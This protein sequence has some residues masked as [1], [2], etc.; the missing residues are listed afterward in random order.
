MQ[1]KLMSL[2]VP[3]GACVAASVDVVM[4]S[5]T[6]SVAVVDA[7]VIVVNS[8]VDSVASSVTVVAS[9]VAGDWLDADVVGSGIL[10]SWLEC[11][12]L[13]LEFLRAMMV[14]ATMQLTS[15]TLRSRYAAR[16]RLFFHENREMING[17]LSVSNCST[18]DIRASVMARQVR[19]S[20][21]R[22]TAKRRCC[23]KDHHQSTT[24]ENHLPI[25]GSSCESVTIVGLTEC[26]SHSFS[27]ILMS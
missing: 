15:R 25:A 12:L 8:V 13:S 1:L 24:I 17:C 5:V 19:A 9:I 22:E 11:V 21:Q 4:P 20:T 16:A 10:L 7:S 26:G 3:G 2:T 14:S 27:F 6:C 18:T 23:F